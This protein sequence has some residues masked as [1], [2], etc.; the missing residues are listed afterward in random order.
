MYFE[1]FQRAPAIGLPADL[2]FG[3]LFIS[4]L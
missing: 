3:K 1:I 2:Y 4:R